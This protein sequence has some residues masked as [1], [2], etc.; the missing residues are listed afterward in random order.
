[1]GGR[2]ASFTKGMSLK[3]MSA[4]ESKL[5][6]L[7]MKRYKTLVREGKGDNYETD[8][9]YVKLAKQRD[10]LRGMINQAIYGGNKSKGVNGFGEATNRY[11]T[12]GTY[13]R[14]MKRQDK[15]IFSRL[16]HWR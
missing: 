16:S 11:I 1:M 6:D 13:N 14:A 10:K 2:G 9:K 5:H 15:E 7:A 8:K 12:S 4:R 3:E